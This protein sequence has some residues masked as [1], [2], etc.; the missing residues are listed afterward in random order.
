LRVDLRQR[1]GGETPLFGP[2]HDRPDAIDLDAF[3]GA[4]STGR[5]T[6]LPAKPPRSAHMVRPELA[7]QRRSP[8]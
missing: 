6:G 4:R 8:L 1:L 2:L 5:E 7:P 3:A